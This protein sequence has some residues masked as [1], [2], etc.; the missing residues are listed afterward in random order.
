MPLERIL[1]ANRS[2]IAIR[3]SR[4]VADLGLTSLGIYSEDDANS[5]HRQAVDIAI[6]LAGRG[7]TA[8][9]DAEKV[10]QLAKDHGA[11][12]IHPGYGFLAEKAEIA[13]RAADA[14]ITF[15][16]PTPELLALFG[17]KTTARSVAEKAGLPILRGTN[18]PTSL[19]G[20]IAFFESLENDSAMM[21]KAVGGGGGRGT[22]IVRDAKSIP[23]AFE[24]CESESLGAFGSGDL[25]V[26]ELIESAR[27][28][29]VQIVGDEAGNVVHLGDRECSVQRRHQKLI[30]IAPAPNLSPQLRQRIQDAAMK[31]AHEVDYCSLGTVEFLLDANDR[32]G[33]SRFAF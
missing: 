16:G 17:D 4:A 32:S 20:A 21:I 11:D 29:E 7:P 9:M 2:E 19:D 27:H 28:I 13:L 10:I 14:G 1:I 25:F 3:I 31:L 5:L 8:Y 12:A 15:V 18:K 22:R 26:E 30:E 23:T 33:E 24:S 6:P